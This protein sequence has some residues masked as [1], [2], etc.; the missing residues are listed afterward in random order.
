MQGVG[1][2]LVRGW[3]RISA[4]GGEVWGVIPVGSASR[5]SPFLQVSEGQWLVQSRLP[6]NPLGGKLHVNSWP[7]KLPGKALPL[8]AESRNLIATGKEM[9]GGPDDGHT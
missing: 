9:V 7:P 4:G 1:G 6:V 3:A 2:R 8:P 5:P